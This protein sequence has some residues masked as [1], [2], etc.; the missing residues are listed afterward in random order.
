MSRPARPD[1]KPL[2][3][4][5]IV[6]VAGL[7]GGVGGAAW[8]WFGND[9]EAGDSALGTGVMGLVAGCFVG[10][11]GVAGRAARRRP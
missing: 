6:L 8:G 2:P 10:A 3:G 5:L 7:Y 9:Y 11:V 4:A 1:E